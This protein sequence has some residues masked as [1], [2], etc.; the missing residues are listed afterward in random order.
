MIVVVSQLLVL[1]PETGPESD[2]DRAAIVQHTRAGF[3]TVSFIDNLS[4]VRQDEVGN[5]DR[6]EVPQW[7]LL[8]ATDYP[9]QERT[10]RRMSTNT[11][12]NV[13]DTQ[14]WCGHLAE[15]RGTNFL[16]VG[17]MYQCGTTGPEYLLVGSRNETSAKQWYAYLLENP[18]SVSTD[19]GFSQITIEQTIKKKPSLK[20]Q[21]AI[22]D[23]TLSLMTDS[24][25]TL[26][27]R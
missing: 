25:L 6:H 7:L 16:V 8:P 22:S 4:V 23:G 27:N 26:E 2:Y 14:L 11:G 12:V 15:Q 20:L 10:G 9:L 5:L 1:D 13:G 18:E 3:L 19:I 21:A 24:I 17:Q